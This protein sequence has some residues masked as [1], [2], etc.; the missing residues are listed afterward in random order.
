MSLPSTQ[1]RTQVTSLFSVIRHGVGEL[2]REL[3]NTQSEL[4]QSGFWRQAGSDFA[5][6]VSEPLRTSEGRK[7]LLFM[8]AA[9]GVAGRVGSVA[10]S[11]LASRIASNNLGARILISGVGFLVN[12]TVFSAASRAVS[13]ETPQHSFLAEVL[14]STFD[15]GGNHLLIAPLQSVFGPLAP[16]LLGGLTLTAISTLRTELTNRAGLTHDS[17]EEHLNNV[18]QNSAFHYGNAIFGAGWH[19]TKSVL[20]RA[21][22]RAADPVLGVA[23]GVGGGAGGIARLLSRRA[24]E[25]QVPGP[26]E[27]SNWVREL[28]A[29]GATD[30]INLG[31]GQNGFGPPVHVREAVSRFAL[32]EAATYGAVAGSPGLIEAIRGKYSA[33]GLEYNDRE[34]VVSA[35]GKASLTLATQTLLNEGDT[36]LI[37]G[38]AWPSY[39]DEVC[40][41]QGRPVVVLGHPRNGYRLTVEQLETA[42][43]ENLQTKL[44]V[45]TNPSNPTGIVY[46]RAE[47]T[48][49]AEVV[50]KHDAIVIADEIYDAHVY[51]GEHV[52]FASLEGM[53]ER[54]ITMNGASKTVGA[55]GWRLTYLVGPEELIQGAVRL[56]SHTAANTSTPIQ[57]GY[58]AALRGS[59]DYI[60]PQVSE[61]RARAEYLTERLNELGLSTP[62]PQGAFYAFANVK[63]YLGRLTPKGQLIENDIQLSRYLL[64]EAH[65][66]TVPGTHFSAPENLRF[67]FGGVDISQLRI[68]TARMEQ[69]LRR[70]RV[71]YT[72]ASDHIRLSENALASETLALTERVVNLVGQG[73]IE[74]AA[75]LLGRLELSPQDRGVFEDL[76][77]DPA[78]VS[79]NKYTRVLIAEAPSGAQLFG[80]IWRTG[81]GAKPHRHLDAHG[82]PVGGIE[83]MVMGEALLNTEYA[84]FTHRESGE[85]AWLTQG[86]LLQGP[87]DVVQI[88]PHTVHTISNPTPEAVVSFNA[89]AGALDMQRSVA[90]EINPPTLRESVSVAPSSER[91]TREGADHAF[92]RIS[93]DGFFERVR[94]NRDTYVVDIRD[95]QEHATQGSVVYNKPGRFFTAPLPREQDGAFDALAFVRNF[96]ALQLDPAIPVVLLCRTGNRTLVDIHRALRLIDEHRR[97]QNLPRYQFLSLHGGVF[98]IFN[99]ASQIVR[100]ARLWSTLALRV[101][102]QFET[103]YGRWTNYPNRQTPIGRDS[104]HPARADLNRPFLKLLAAVP[105]E[106]ENL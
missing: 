27:V 85:K 67:A 51:Q 39:R 29:S 40:L 63:R 1:T 72:Q 17:V 54:T 95:L 74:E 90:F 98:G 86:V 89:Y 52:P 24:Q 2:K 84:S 56:Q 12:A 42:F 76:A 62:A 71:P 35:G 53:R 22:L 45:L 87:K 59:Q 37:L 11:L 34:V 10:S 15:F 19:T 65:V 81:Q 21:A 102:P 83:R 48:A 80:M 70:L 43:Q 100:D 23:L 38:P 13:Q 97:E 58:E 66:A 18:V 92:E 79:Q 88:Q 26:A 9:G 8:F 47:L 3:E 61:F 32:N 5:A 30:I 93:I 50:A 68:A 33:Q 69:A 91:L 78:L 31:M 25:T 96:S 7:N 14:N 105:E 103:V 106:G 82:N 28:Q 44:V 6:A 75:S 60:R 20:G 57:A 64:D 41:A 94:E 16:F 104:N 36:A 4:Y 49:F 99:R 73:K 101:G 55:A 77:G 46:S